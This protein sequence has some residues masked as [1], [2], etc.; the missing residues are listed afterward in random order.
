MAKPRRLLEH[1]FPARTD[2]LCET[3]RLVREALNELGCDSE[4][5]ETMAL[6]IDEATANVLRHA[7]KGDESQVVVLEM[8]IDGDTLITKL[9]DFAP[10]VDH[11]KIKPR[12][13]EDIRPGG[14]G[15]HIIQ[16]VMD[17]MEYM[18]L[19]DGDGN[20]LLMKRKL[21]V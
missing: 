19:D 10:P 9:I 1:R 15:V 5:I 13:L 7:Y 18:H 12:D 8:Y 3:R 20:V 17:S 16:E 21:S 2:Q 14:L 4:Y 11:S 6:A